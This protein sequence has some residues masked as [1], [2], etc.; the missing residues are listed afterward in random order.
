MDSGRSGRSF[1]LPLLPR[2]VAFIQ[3]KLPADT[4]EIPTKVLES[5]DTLDELEDWLMAKNPRLMR[6]LRQARQDDLAGKFKPWKPRHLSCPTGSKQVPKRTRNSRSWTP[7]L[8]RASN[9]KSSG[10]GKTPPVH[11]RQKTVFAGVHTT[12]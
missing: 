1:G 11:A 12:R 10:S 4:V 8:A 3:M 2:R 6:E 5:V 7:R 9:A